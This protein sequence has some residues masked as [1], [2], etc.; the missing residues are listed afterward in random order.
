[1]P[2]TITRYPSLVALTL[3]LIAAPALAQ[4]SWEGSVQ[5]TASVGFPTGNIDSDG[6]GND[7]VLFTGGN[8]PIYGLANQ[9]D[10]TGVTG[11]GLPWN[12]WQIW[13]NYDSAQNI[14]VGDASQSGTLSI[15]AAGKLRYQHLVIGAVS[16][17]TAPGANGLNFDVDDRSFDVTSYNNGGVAT[18]GTGLVTISGFGS[19][20]NNDPNLISRSDQIAL[21]LGNG[22]PTNNIVVDLDAAV[23]PAGSPAT[24]FSTRA[25]NEGY[26]V[27]VGLDGT[28]ALSI[29][30]GGRAEIQDALMVGV[31]SQS[32]GSVTIDGIGSSLSAFGRTRLTAT[33]TETR[34]NET[35]SFVGGRGTGSLTVSNGGRAEFFNGLA[36]GSLSGN[37]LGTTGRGS[38]PGDGSGT[39]TV[40]GAGSLMNLFPSN[41]AGT[42]DNRALVVGEIRSNANAG[43]DTPFLPGDSDLQGGTLNISDAAIVNVAGRN[44]QTG[45]AAI[46]KRGIVNVAGGQFQIDNDLEIDGTVKGYG[47][48]RSNTIETSAYSVIR[49][50]DP[51]SPNTALT[52]PLQLVVLNDSDD[53]NDPALLN[54][55]LIDGRV[56]LEVSGT[57]VNSGRIETSGEITAQSLVTTPTSR[58]RNFPSGQSPIRM[59]LTSTRAAGADD[60]DDNFGALH[61]RGLIDGDLD[62]I[63]AGGVVNGDNYLPTSAAPA[64]GS[65]ASGTISGSG[66][67]LASQFLNNADAEVRVRQGE[68]LT[69][70]TGYATAAGANAGPANFPSGAGIPVVGGGGQLSYR[71]LNLGSISV[72]GGDLEI[73]YLPES[74]G[75]ID[76]LNAGGTAFNNAEV[77]T[78]A[79]YAV[80]DTA[81]P[82]Q[83][84]DNTAGTI[85]AN[86]ATLHFTTGLLNMGGVLAFTGGTNTVNGPVYNAFVDYGTAMN[87]APLPGT[88]IVSGDGTS[89]TFED[90][91][92]NDGE[93]GIGPFGSVVNFLGDLTGGGNIEVAFDALG[94]SGSAGAYIQVSG[95][96]SIQGGTIGFAFINQPAATV[97]N[98]FSIALIT[99][100]ELDEASLFTGLDLPDLPTG[101]YWDVVYDTVNDEVRLEVVMS[102]AFGAD[103]TGD[104]VV[105]QD[106]VDV[107]IRNAGIVS[108]ASIIQ[109]DADHDGDVDLADYDVLMAQFYTGV[110]EVVGG[111][112]ALANVPEPLS[113][114]LLCLALAP[115]VARRR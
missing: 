91:V 52:D 100:G 53:A 102:N 74:G 51:N 66:R 99:A 24:T 58:I 61:N 113:A 18:G 88:I 64:N 50:G 79:R 108:G 76:F 5:P 71:T 25:E 103:F 54:R 1:M 3:S 65:A 29:E 84:L 75:P 13:S 106:D 97:D 35:A 33:L 59:N 82:G 94:T 48:V 27:I 42:F 26:D 93:I 34:S 49:G 72:T 23:Q 87:P 19:L 60:G 39:V 73:G 7:D 11:F 8:N 14:L 17:G 36:I 62:I 63:S 104:G 22:D 85:V 105:T 20:F 37:D 4:I 31:D 30:A 96:V 115:A 15:F 21:N 69:I 83:F 109:G 32:N 57:I 46:G 38:T 40:T 114:V 67:I 43:L 41:I 28:G 9:T 101:K 86:D 89:V 98:N 77:F 70:H 111:F 90:D 12:A 80:P 44:G 68:S 107:W 110:P 16:E 81:N 45:N 112:V 78:N 47:V 6:D 10:P 95:G 55:G 56:Q 2:R 92:I